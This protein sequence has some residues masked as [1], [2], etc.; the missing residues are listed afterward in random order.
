MTVPFYLSNSII[1][2]TTCL[3]VASL[4]HSYD[5]SFYLNSSLSNEAFF[6]CTTTLKFASLFHSIGYDTKEIHTFRQSSENLEK[7]IET[8]AIS[9]GR[10]KVVRS[11]ISPPSSLLSLSK[12]SVFLE[13]AIRKERKEREKASA[14]DCWERNQR[15]EEKQS[16][17]NSWNSNSRLPPCKKKRKKRKRRR[18][19]SDR[20][21]L[22]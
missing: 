4:F 20:S 14:I 5:H 16:E 11:R 19:S 12:Y 6:A 7:E 17:E 10:K 13:Y 8:I 18:G 22:Y 1:Y 15:S 9:K 3:I 21:R 2:Y